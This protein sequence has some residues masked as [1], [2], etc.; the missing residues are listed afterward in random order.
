MNLDMFTVHFKSAQADHVT[1][2]LP[3]PIPLPGT[4]MEN[5]GWGSK[6]F[7]IRFGSFCA[8]DYADVLRRYDRHYSAIK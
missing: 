3:E 6:F 2:T 8:A 7:F 4:I 5:W 1:G